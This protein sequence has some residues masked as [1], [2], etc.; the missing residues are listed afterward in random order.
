MLPRSWRQCFAG[1]NLA[2]FGE[3]L[4]RIDA[5]RHVVDDGDIDAHAGFQRPQLFELLT[6][7]E[8]RW[9][10]RDEALERCAAIGVKSDM[11]VEWPLAGGRGS[12]GEIKRTQP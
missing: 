8:R 10:Q 12:A 11:V 6:P 7:L 5:E 9:W 2:R 3:I 4:R 1:E